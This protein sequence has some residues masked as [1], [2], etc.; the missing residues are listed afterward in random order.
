MFFPPVDK[1]SEVQDLCAQDINACQVIM[2]PQL[3]SFYPVVE[4]LRPILNNFCQIFETF[5]SDITSKIWMQIFPQNVATL[6]DLV[7]RV[8]PKFIG[9]LQD[10]VVKMSQLTVPCE[11]AAFLMP[12]GTAPQQLRNV[13]EGLKACHELSVADN[14]NVNEVC[15]KVQLYDSLKAVSKQAE[16]LLSVTQKFELE[17]DFAIVVNIADVRS[18][19]QHYCSIWTMC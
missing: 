16:Q 7:E 4:T 14:I 5:H 13:L 18:K 9:K 17:G 2:L 12:S 3:V 6:Q 10:M 1:L 15:S 11:E 8:W 19:A